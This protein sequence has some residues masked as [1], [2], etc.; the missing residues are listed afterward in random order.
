MK[1]AIEQSLVSLQYVPVGD[2]SYKSLWGEK[3]VE[4]FL[5]FSAYG[6][7]KQFL[8][9]DFGL[10]NRE[11]EQFSVDLIKEIGGKLYRTWRH[12][13]KRDCSMRF[14]FGKLA[15]W[16][17][18]WSIDVLRISE[19]ELGDRIQT[20]I[21]RFLF[22]LVKHI[23]TTQDL[24]DVLMLDR[25]PFRWLHVNS[26]V[27]AAQIAFLARRTGT[28]SR[29]IRLILLPFEAEIA[30]ALPKSVVVKDFIEELVTRTRQHFE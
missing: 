15:G 27:R 11:A 28:D 22:P 30:A 18:R 17:P 12:N 6:A 2:F 13:A 29:E 20:D 14:P 25:D 3:N 16:A 19:R 21:T 8:S 7:P 26:A 5:Y 24:L 1:R 23:A 9:A 10:R 4:H